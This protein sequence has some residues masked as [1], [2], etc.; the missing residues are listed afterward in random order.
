[1]GWVGYD[2]SVTVARRR[3]RY[4]ELRL[5]ENARNRNRDNVYGVLVGTP[6]VSQLESGR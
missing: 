5:S 1:M 4:H 3:R 6:V 2:S